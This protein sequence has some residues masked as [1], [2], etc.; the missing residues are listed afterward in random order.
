MAKLTKRII[1]KVERHLKDL[2]MDNPNWKDLWD[3]SLTVE[4][5]LKNIIGSEKTFRF[6]KGE[7]EY[8]D[9]LAEK[10]E[11][12]YLKS[13]IER[14]LEAIKNS[15]SVELDKYYAKLKS[16]LN[17]LVNNDEIYSLFLIGDI[18]TGKTFNTIRF[19]VERNI[20]FEY[21]VGNISPLEMYHILYENKNGLIIFDDTQALIR[22][23]QS[24]SIL[25]SALWSATGH[26]IIE[27]R[28]TS[29]KL[30]APSIFE[31]CG[32]IIFCLNEIPQDVDIR[33]LLSR[34]FTYELSFDYYTMLKIMYEIAKLPHKHLTK[35]ERIMIV[36]FIRDNSSPATKDFNLRL[37]KKIE[38][39]Y[40]Y[41]KENW[42]E[43][44]LELLKPDSDL[45][46]VKQLVEKNI[47]VKDAVKEWCELTGKSRRSFFYYKSKLEKV[48]II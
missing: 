18:G 17:I 35:E 47:K 3:S 38:I 32:K 44:A 45:L 20:P 29:R 33:T 1:Q 7:M 8:W 14:D 9:S 21:V 5:N 28:T 19:L 27:W 31:F 13:L 2:G 34:C 12:E 24:L 37:Q 41:D 42:K 48:R 4:E 10:E 23:K 11:K 22:N 25:L 40:R 6:D 30:K 15:S 16:M 46:L 43:L 26:R 39:I 36:D